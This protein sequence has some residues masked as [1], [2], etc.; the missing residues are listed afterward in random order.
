MKRTNLIL[1]ETLLKQAKQLLEAESYSATVN[2]ALEEVIKS[3]NI[4]R[5]VDLFG[6]GAWSGDLSVMRE[7][8]PTKKTKAASRKS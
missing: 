2:Q 8:Q 7:D 3:H 6:T 1:D 5:L 4:R